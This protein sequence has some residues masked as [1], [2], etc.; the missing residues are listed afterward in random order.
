MNCT[1]YLA[2]NDHEHIDL[3]GKVPVGNVVFDS[4]VKNQHTFPLQNTSL[5]L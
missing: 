4:I 2:S 3:Y 5:Y 1:A